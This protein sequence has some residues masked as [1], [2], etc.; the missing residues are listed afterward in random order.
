[1]WRID[2]LES[3]RA[4]T[5][6]TGETRT[7]AVGELRMPADRSA[8]DTHGADTA[9][10][11]VATP[12]LPMIVGQ[13]VRTARGSVPDPERGMYYSNDRMIAGMQ[14][15]A[16]K[17]SVVANGQSTRSIVT[18]PQLAAFSLRCRSARR[19]VP[20]QAADTIVADHEPFPAGSI[21][22]RR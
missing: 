9:S 13:C 3:V 14:H 10:D 4:T 1:M 8:L 5:V 7:I 15:L 21:R 22:K 17:H 19:Y 12:V 6:K 2:R 16:F 18:G 20:S 11:P